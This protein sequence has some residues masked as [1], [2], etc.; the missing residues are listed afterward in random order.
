MPSSFL[1]QF[2]EGV[3]IAFAAIPLIPTLNEP[4]KR[5]VQDTF[6]EALEVVWQTVL[7]IAFAGFLGSLGMRQL[8]LHTQ[9]D[10]EWSREDLPTGHRR[11]QPSS[12]EMMDQTT[13]VKEA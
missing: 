12:S 3:Q 4:F 11:Q 1:Q 8:T 2:P 13:L 5:D 10:E 9:I 7:G 6:A